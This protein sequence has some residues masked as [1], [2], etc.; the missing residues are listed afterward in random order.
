M[1]D[2][3]SEFAHVNVSYRAEKDVPPPGIN[4]NAKTS[5]IKTS[6]TITNIVD[7]D[8][9]LLQKLGYSDV[10]YRGFDGFMS[11]AFCFTSVAVLSSISSSWPA[12]ITT[13]GPATVIYTWIIGAFFTLLTGIAMAEICSTYP[14]AGSVYF[15]TSAL[16]PIEYADVLGYIDGIFNL[17]GNAA[18]DA[19]YA[20]AF[21]SIFASA[22]SLSPNPVTLT[23]GQ[24]VG[25]AIAI[26]FFWA[27]VNILRVDQQG[28]V[29]NFATAWQIC[30][31]IAI[32]IVLLVNTPNDPNV[33]ST[34]V[35]TTGYNG[36]GIP[37][38]NIGYVYVIGLLSALFAFAG[39]EAG[40]HMAEETKDASKS[41]AWG[42]VYTCISVAILGFVYIL[43]LAYSTTSSM[44]MSYTQWASLTDD[45]NTS[46]SEY[47]YLAIE[48]VASFP[49]V[50]QLYFSACGSTVGMILTA[51]LLVNLIFAGIS[52]LT[53]TTRIAF[54]LARDNALP[55]SSYLTYIWPTTKSP[56]YT[57][58]AVFLFDSIILLLP[59]ASPIALNAILSIS[60][61]GYQISYA[62]PLFLRITY[63]RNTFTQSTFNLGKYSLVIHTIASIWLI[64]TSLIFFWPVSWPVSASNM[65]WTVVVVGGSAILS[66]IWWYAYAKYHYHGPRSREKQNLENHV[67]F[68]KL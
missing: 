14:S 44:G 28:W 25:I 58:L 51:V 27:L 49:S 47:L 24:T 65:N 20:W 39:Y 30:T 7:N 63:A 53:V 15:W 60:V 41:A 52:S 12:S 36:T 21:A 67:P 1:S 18:G 59:L 43:G 2:T 31:T 16:A 29:N 22:L 11:F 13:G 17:L 10:L 57:I 26:S 54:A 38:A 5:T 34:W 46:L 35:W 32:I 37:D 66:M 56:L 33:P 45:P 42:I 48:N 61:I 50:T 23:V 40:G 4:Q 8:A 3:L 64:S 6:D 68:P 62:M 9:I 55:F 19:T